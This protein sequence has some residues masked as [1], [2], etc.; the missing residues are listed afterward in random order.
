VCWISTT[1]LAAFGHAASSSLSIVPLSPSFPTYA[2]N[3][4]GSFLMAGAVAASGVLA[5]NS[6]PLAMTVAKTSL[7][8]QIAF[9][10]AVLCNCEYF[11]AD[12]IM[13]RG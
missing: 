9:I 5:T 10:R 2:G 13:R 1:F 7:D 4:I 8:W 12:I 11:A 6:L 3:Y